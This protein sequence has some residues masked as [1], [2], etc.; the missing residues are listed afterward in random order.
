MGWRANKAWGSAKPPPATPIAWGNPIATGLKGAWTFSEGAGL[1]AGEASGLAGGTGA[2]QSGITWAPG[3][4][5]PALQFDSSH[6]VDIGLTARSQIS[7]PGEMTVAMWINP[8]SVGA[9]Q[10]LA[11]DFN[12]GGSLSQWAV[13]I[14]AAG[15]IQT[16][17]NGGSGGATGG[18]AL[19][20]GTWYQIVC[21]RKGAA[22]AWTY[23]IYVNAVQDGYVVNVAQN[24]DA[25]QGA[26]IGRAGNYA[27]GLQYGGKIDSFFLFNRAWTYEQVRE[28]Y[29]RGFGILFAPPRRRVI[30]QAVAAV[31]TPPGSSPVSIFMYPGA[32]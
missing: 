10:Y 29:A 21:T 15:V 7:L 16:L 19:A 25:Q 4:F 6:V 1:I 18:L 22:G 20:A 5:G 32:S 13:N 8:A 17:A 2:I 3:K 26:C 30:S 28:I 12:S 23:S 9:Q 11:G 14:T 27:G 31:G 24:P